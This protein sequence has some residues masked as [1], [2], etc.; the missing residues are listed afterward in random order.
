[1]LANG[2]SFATQVVI[3]LVIGSYAGNRG[4]DLISTPELVLDGLVSTLWTNGELGLVCTVL[5]VSCTHCN[6]LSAICAF[7]VILSLETTIQYDKV[8]GF[9]MGILAVRESCAD[10]SSH[11]ECEYGLSDVSPFPSAYRALRSV[12]RSSALPVQAGGLGDDCWTTVNDP[13]QQRFGLGTKA[14]FTAVMVR[15]I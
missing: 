9:G 2:V 10:C 14:M 7:I 4:I 15:I 12:G 6:M 8:G 1:M 5:D 3:L 11:Y 13:L